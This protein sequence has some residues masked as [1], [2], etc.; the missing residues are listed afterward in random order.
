MTV[1]K[2]LM[3]VRAENNDSRDSPLSITTVIPAMVKLDSAIEVA[4]TTFR[5]PEADGRIASSCCSSFM[6]PYSGI[7]L[8]CAGKCFE[9]N[10]RSVL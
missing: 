4:N 5:L 7:T 2:R 8:T 10:S 1:V 6:L 9:A 3:P